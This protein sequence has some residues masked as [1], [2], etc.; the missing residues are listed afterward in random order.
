[1]ILYRPFRPAA[2]TLAWHS[3]ID[4]IRLLPTVGD[5]TAEDLRTE[6]IAREKLARLTAMY[7]NQPIPPL[8]ERAQSTIP[9]PTINVAQPTTPSSAGPG[10]NTIGK[11]R[12]GPS[13]SLSPAPTPSFESQTQSQSHSLNAASPRVKSA[14]SVTPVPPPS[15][16]VKVKKEAYHDQLPLQAGR[17]VAFK[18]PPSSKA[19]GGEEEE[20]ILVTIRRCLGDKIKYEVVDAD[21][22]KT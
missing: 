14:R 22:N 10:P 20:W 12:R 6:E 8:S 2:K 16:S 5:K 13:I 7:D 17:R 9:T 15:S 19:E 3:F 4:T 11:R 21:D 18:V 1:V